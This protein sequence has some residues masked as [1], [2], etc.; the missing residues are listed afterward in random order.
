MGDMADWQIDQMIA[1]TED[2]DYGLLEQEESDYLRYRGKCREFC[3]A[4]I[5]EDPTLTPGPWLLP[6]PLLGQ[7][8]ALVEFDG[9]CSCEECG[10]K[11]KEE[12]AIMCGH[13]PVCSQ[14]CAMRLVGL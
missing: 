3:D 6:L 2:D 7:A 10:K 4:A 14:G 9:W 1:P 11:V 5:L 12:D 13:Y 8:G